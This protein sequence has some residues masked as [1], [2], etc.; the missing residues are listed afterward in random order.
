MKRYLPFIFFGGICAV[1][2]GYLY[3]ND[4]LPTF[5]QWW[6]VVKVT[7]ISLLILY[8]AVPV[9]IYGRRSGL[10]FIVGAVALTWFMSLFG[11]I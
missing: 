11:C 6:Y 8:I 5:E 2:L 3:L 9:L 4:Y 10:R 1:I 7:F